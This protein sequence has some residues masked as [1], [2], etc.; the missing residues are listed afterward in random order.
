MDKNDPSSWSITANH[1]H[2]FADMCNLSFLSVIVALILAG[3]ETQH[4][5]EE[6]KKCL[7]D[8]N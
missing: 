6:I 8:V 7:H 5:V 4:S 2:E 3:T 1:S